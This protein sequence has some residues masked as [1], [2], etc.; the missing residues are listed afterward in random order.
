MT[1][2]APMLDRGQFSKLFP[3]HFILDV[4]MRI[5]DTGSVLARICPKVVPGADIN[6]HFLM[7]RLGSEPV[8]SLS[9]DFILRQQSTLFVFKSTSTDLMLRCQVLILRDH[10]RYLF[11]GSPW[12]RNPTELKALHLVLHDFALHDSTVDLLQLVQLTSTSLH[13]AK[14][15]SEKLEQRVADRTAELVLANSELSR[16]MRSKDDF[17]SAMSHELRTPLN[18]ILG[19]SESL[20]EGVYGDMNVKQVKSINTIAESG[21]HLLALIND[22]LDIA[23]IGAGKMELELTNTH[24]EDVCQASL[25]L[26]LELAQKK[27]LKLALSMDNKSVMLTADERRLKQILVNLL[28]NAIKFTPEGGSVTLATT[29]DVESE[30]LMFSVRD[31]GIGIAAEDLSRLF[32][33]FT[34]LDSKLSRQYAGT[35]LGLTLVLR[36]VEMHGG[37][38]TVE[39]EIGKGS[40]FT[41]RIPCKGLDTLIPH[42]PSGTTTLSEITSIQELPSNTP[43]ILVADDNEI[44]LMTVTDYLRA[45]KLRVIQARD[46]LEAVKMVREHAPSLVLMDIQMPLMDGLDAIAHL[47]T[48]DKHTAMPIIALTSRA[49]VGDRERCMA[50]G[51]NDYLSKPV[52]MKQLV[53]TIHTHLPKNETR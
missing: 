33:P 27:N 46:G 29:C 39:S 49:M 43:L 47:R 35:G 20:A 26:V 3:F 34:Q 53:K 40:C 7:F 48:D 22:L 17:L 21:H 31:T 4:D 11:L 38:V 12:V 30:S 15:L 13:D 28:S 50:V 10:E 25:R 2:S 42:N 45:N 14:Q 6:D 36:L 32:S 52:N 1:D 5:L 23:K 41:I 44:N 37:S 24:V 18:A 9:R 8:K 51:A 16:V 19:L